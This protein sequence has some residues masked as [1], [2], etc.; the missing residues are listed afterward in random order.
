[1]GFRSRR[2]AIQAVVR[3]VPSDD[4]SC[5]IALADRSSRAV[6]GAPYGRNAITPFDFCNVLIA[7]SIEFEANGGSIDLS[8]EDCR[9]KVPNTVF[10][11][12]A[13]PE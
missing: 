10:D 5:Q 11:S 1:M 13:L 2:G 7:K 12:V 6:R 8:G 9:S 4:V 3:G